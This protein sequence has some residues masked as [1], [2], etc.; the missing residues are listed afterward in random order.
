MIVI[1]FSL[2]AGVKIDDIDYDVELIIVSGL[3]ENKAQ[4]KNWYDVGRKLGLSRSDLNHI[5]REDLR[6]GGSPTKVLID[7]LVTLKS[8]VTVRCFVHAL[9]YL[10]RHDIVNRV[11]DFYRNQELT[12]CV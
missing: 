8:V 10:G 3:D 12:S 4:A 1:G 7:K 9:H 6:Q 2:F 5:K 11:F